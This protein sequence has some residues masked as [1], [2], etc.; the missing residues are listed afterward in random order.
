MGHFLT[1]CPS[2]RPDAPAGARRVCATVSHVTRLSP[3]HD[4]QGP[5]L[6]GVGGCGWVLGP[7]EAGIYGKFVYQSQ[8]EVDILQEPRG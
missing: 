5:I 4:S 6:E 1:T 8:Q 3:L 2:A 7:S